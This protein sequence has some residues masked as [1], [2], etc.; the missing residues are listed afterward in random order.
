MAII[1]D[2]L[3]Q[4]LLMWSLQT[5]QRI[6]K[7]RFFKSYSSQLL[8]KVIMKVVRRVCTFLAIQHD[9]GNLR[10]TSQLSILEH[11]LESKKGKEGRITSTQ[12]ESMKEVPKKR[13][14]Q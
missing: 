11:F 1:Y 2:T 12:L 4:E 3:Q 13:V 6:P 10:R 9:Q 14:V 7:S 8:K 5:Q